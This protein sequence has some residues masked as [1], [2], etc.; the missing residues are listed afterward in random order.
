MSRRVT[1]TRRASGRAP[2]AARF[3]GAPRRRW[4]A[5]MPSAAIV[6]ATRPTLLTRR[7]ASVTGGNPAP[8]VYVYPLPRLDREL[9]RH[10][11]HA[12]R[13]ARDLASLAPFSLR[14]HRPA[15][16]HHA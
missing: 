4:P 2:S 5:G 7:A 1:P 10:A 16:R 9:I 8:A 3:S 13:A 12:S 6:R 11:L 15:E 14:L